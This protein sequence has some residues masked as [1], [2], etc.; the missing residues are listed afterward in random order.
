VVDA[1]LLLC[2]ICGNNERR[3]CWGCDGRGLVTRER[4]AELW[5][6]VAD[7]AVEELRAGRAVYLG[8]SSTTA[9]TDLLEEKAKRARVDCRITFDA[10]TGFEALPEKQPRQGL[11]KWLVRHSRLFGRLYAYVYL[12][13]AHPGRG[14][15]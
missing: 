2:P 8:W 15:S 9:E 14:G 13:Y 10:D 11:L 6:D 4:R 12:R 5:P 7:R 1:D 3:N